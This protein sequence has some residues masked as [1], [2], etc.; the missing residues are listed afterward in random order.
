MLYSFGSNQFGQL[1]ID[2][3]PKKSKNMKSEYDTMSNDEVPTGG[4]ASLRNYSH[5]ITCEKL[6]FCNRPTL[7]TGTEF[8][9]ETIKSIASGDH[10]NLL[11]TEKG[12]VYSWGL[13]SNC[14]LGVPKRKGVIN[15]LVNRGGDKIAFKPHHLESLDDAGIVK[16]TARREMS[17]AFSSETGDVFTWGSFPKG[18]ALENHAKSYEEPTLHNKLSDYNF[19]DIQFT[20]DSAIAI[21]GSIQLTFSFVDTSESSTPSN[22]TPG[23]VAGGIKKIA[24]EYFDVKVHAI[25]IIDG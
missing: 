8:D 17:L 4:A 21:G 23:I 22:Q 15:R 3:T 10:H 12:K 7:V 1:G 13:A 14:Q 9:G 5:P 25:P 6:T 16:I 18:L 20:K 19:L 24:K 2:P 11:L